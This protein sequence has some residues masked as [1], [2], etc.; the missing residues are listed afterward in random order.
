MNDIRL[1]WE[2]IL[3]FSRTHQV[4]QTDILIAGAI[5][6]V[7]LLCIPLFLGRPRRDSGAIRDRWVLLALDPQTESDGLI[8][9]FKKAAW[10]VQPL[11][12]NSSLTE[13]LTGFNPTLL[14]VDQSLFGNELTRLEASEAK[15]ASTPILYLNANQVDRSAMPMR[16]WLSSNA[17]PKTILEQA[18]RLVRARPGSQQL[19]RKSE[20]QGPLGPGTLLELLYFQ[21]N[22]QRTGR[23]EISYHGLSGWLW[24]HRGEVKHAVVAG[25]EGVEALNAMLNL[26][27][28]HYSFV[29]NVP[30][31]STTIRKPTVF[32]L[33]EYARQRDEL[34]KMAGN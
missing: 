15:V 16:A 14:L 33:H 12:P 2:E 30:P 3:R 9:I 17:R 13:F 10:D 4:E 21:A 29:A 25:I 28:G 18:E 7:V 24:I 8:E 23:M 31:P 27:D 34:G 1:W 20:V 5:A 19:S 11:P 26:S 32:L 22:T 6:A